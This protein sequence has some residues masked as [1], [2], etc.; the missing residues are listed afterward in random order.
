VKRE[1][2]ARFC[3]RRRVRFPPPTHLIAD[4]GAADRLAQ[5][6]RGEGGGELL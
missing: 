5:V 3:E 4:P 1:F 6:E 2:H